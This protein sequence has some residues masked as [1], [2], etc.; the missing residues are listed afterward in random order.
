VDEVFVGEVHEGGFRDVGAGGVVVEEGEE[1]V[2][3]VGLG[4]EDVGGEG[5]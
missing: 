3:E 1:G 5:G 2:G 4:G